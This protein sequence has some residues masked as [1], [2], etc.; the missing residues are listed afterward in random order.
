[1]QHLKQQFGSSRQ[2]AEMCC[3]HGEAT[4]WLKP[5]ERITKRIWSIQ[6]LFLFCQSV[7]IGKLNDKKLFGGWILIFLVQNTE[8]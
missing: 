3:I 8:L 6:I 5:R 1:M 2:A 7:E 4:S